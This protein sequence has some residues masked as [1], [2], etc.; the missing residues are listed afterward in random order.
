[1]LA[2]S[3][4]TQ[5]CSAKL[6]L[7]TPDNHP[8]IN[9]KGLTKQNRAKQKRRKKKKTTNNNKNIS[10]PSTKKTDLKLLKP[11]QQLVASARA[12]HPL[13]P[14]SYSISFSKLESTHSAPARYLIIKHPSVSAALATSPAL[15]RSLEVTGP[16]PTPINHCS[17][18]EAQAQG[19]SGKIIECKERP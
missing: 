3:L 15:H 6:E 17:L 11:E 2:G 9:W 18:A 10:S 7:Q 12:P 16:L 5:P 13:P 19:S 8:S 1:M 14:E 4:L